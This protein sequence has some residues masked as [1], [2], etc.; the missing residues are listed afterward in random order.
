MHFHIHTQTHKHRTAHVLHTRNAFGKAWAYNISSAKAMQHT[1]MCVLQ[2]PIVR[3]QWHRQFHSTIAS[4]VSHCV[5]FPLNSNCILQSIRPI[6]PSMAPMLYVPISQNASLA[7]MPISQGM[8][9][10]M[11]SV[12]HAPLEP[13]ELMGFSAGCAGLENSQIGLGAPIAQHVRTA[14]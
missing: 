2:S 4:V 14:A 11:W 7:N 6:F 12:P 8:P 5:K 1:T 13:M 9:H 10:T 3:F